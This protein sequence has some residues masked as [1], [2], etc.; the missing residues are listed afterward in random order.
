MDIVYTITLDE[1]ISLLV[2]TR[3][4][5]GTTTSAGD[6]P[7][8]VEGYINLGDTGLE[9]VFIVDNQGEYLTTIYRDVFQ[10]NIV[11]YVGWQSEEIDKAL[12]EKAIDECKSLF[13]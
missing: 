2:V 8:E 5:K 1:A 3:F 11:G 13:K 6:D 10:N 9:R 7:C 12:Y 4:H